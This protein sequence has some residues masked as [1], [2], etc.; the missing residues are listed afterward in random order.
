[1]EG[2]ERDH[3]HPSIP[4]PNSSLLQPQ[5]PPIQLLPSRLLDL[6]QHPPV[7]PLRLPFPQ[8]PKEERVHVLHGQKWWEQGDDF[9]GFEFG[10]VGGDKG[11]GWWD[12]EGSCRFGVG[13]G[14]GVGVG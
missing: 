10:G 2:S 8:R 6:P 11:E 5:Q 12:E 3:L 4:N 9:E 7:V 14:F 1:M 13:F